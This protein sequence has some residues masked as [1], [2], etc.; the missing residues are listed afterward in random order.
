MNWNREQTLLRIASGDVPFKSL[1][2]P[3]GCASGGNTQRLV[4][5][6][7]VSHAD[8]KGLATARIADIGATAGISRTSVAR[9]LAALR[10]HGY[11]GSPFCARG[12]DAH[13]YPI[14]L[15]REPATTTGSAAA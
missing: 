3:S 6:Y 9:N 10:R 1:R 8:E 12:S 14:L 15:G 11:I 13:M 5:A 7:L 4:M 2:E